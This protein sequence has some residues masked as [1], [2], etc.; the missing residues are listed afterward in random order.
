ME[1]GNGDRKRGC[2]YFGKRFGRVYLCRPINCV[3]S[4]AAACRCSCRF[5]DPNRSGCDAAQQHLNGQAFGRN[6]PGHFVTWFVYIQ[7]CIYLGIAAQSGSPTTKITRN[8]A[9]IQW[10]IGHKIVKIDSFVD[11]WKVK[12]SRGI[13]FR[14]AYME[15][16]QHWPSLRHLSVDLLPDDSWLWISSSLTLERHVG[17]LLNQNVLRSFHDLWPLCIQHHLATPFHYFT[18]TTTTNTAIKRH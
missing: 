10:L 4:P 18:T 8:S 11:A 2:T 3:S 13:D 5:P 12:Q 1:G 15:K 7:S 6:S 9:K 17:V 14:L 16:V